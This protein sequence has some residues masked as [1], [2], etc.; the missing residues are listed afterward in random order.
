V[1]LEA[2]VEATRTSLQQEEEKQRETKSENEL[3]ADQKSEFKK[4]IEALRAESEELGAKVAKQRKEH[5]ELHED[6]KLV[7]DRGFTP[8]IVNKLKAANIDGAELDALLQ[9]RE[10]RNELN[11]KVA[12]LEEKESTLTRKIEIL[13]EK[14]Q[15]LEKKLAS[16]ENRLDLLEA[17]E[18]VV[19]D[20]AD[21][22][23]A[24]IRDGYTPGQLKALVL[25]LRKLEIRENPALSINHLLQCLAEAKS[26]LNLKHEVGLAEKRLDELLK[27]ED[28]VRARVEIVQNAVMNG[29]EKSRKQGEEAIA[30]VGAQARGEVSRVASQSAD[31]IKTVSGAF[32]EAVN[33]SVDELARLQEEKGRLEHLVEPAWVLTGIIQYPKCLKTVSPSLVNILLQ[34]LAMWC[35]QELPNGDVGAFYDIA[36]NEFQLNNAAFPRFRIS[37]LIRLGAEGIRRQIVQRLAEEPKQRRF[38]VL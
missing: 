7:R 19:Q 38:A 6:V 9:Q 15:N 37:A 29:I 23:K 4:D 36:A 14:I 12:A 28:E 32:S 11:E 26:L 10:K 31:G 30:S 25:L 24:A 34:N 22:L 2:K 5:E 35:E 1:E 33:R 21:I 13:P 17:Q 3:L 18:A 27:A 16:K 8:E 20:V